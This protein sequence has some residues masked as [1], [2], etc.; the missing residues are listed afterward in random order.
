ML[1][2]LAALTR[3]VPAAGPRAVALAVYAGSDGVHVTARERGEEGVACVDDAARALGLLSRLWLVTGNSALQT[4]AEGLLDFVLWM[5]DGTGSYVNFI[6]DWEGNKNIAGPTS[7]P[8]VNF[9]Q[10]RATCA[11]VDAARILGDDSARAAAITAFGRLAN[12]PNV[13]SDVRA[14]HVQ[15]GLDLLQ[16][17][18]DPEIADHVSA[19][20]GEIISWRIGPM[21]MNSPDERGRPHLWGHI[22]EAVL[23]DAAH[24]LDRPELLK[25]ATDSADAVFAEAINGRFDLPAGPYDVQS[26]VLVMD[27]LAYRTGSAEYLRLADLARAWFDGR[28]PADGPTYDRATGRVHDGI[29]AGRLNANCGAEAAVSAGLALLQDRQVLALAHGWA[30]PA[31]APQPSRHLAGVA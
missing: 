27:R 1:R 20:C 2:Q 21:L 16:W 14:L 13:P 8:A 28:N 10:A 23:A 25:V 26:A 7:A 29:D 18:P 4:W 24:V 31:I 11:L 6:F 3:R 17:S 30:H 12:A 15:A 9:W 5:H 19:W 22:Q